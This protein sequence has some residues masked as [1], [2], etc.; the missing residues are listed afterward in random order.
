ML[1]SVY[2]HVFL[3]ATGFDTDRLPPIDDVVPAQPKKRRFMHEVWKK[4]TPALRET[5]EQCET[6]TSTSC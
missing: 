2:S 4:M 3:T 1:T 5:R 6:P